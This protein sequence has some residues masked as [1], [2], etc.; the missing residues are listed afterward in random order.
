M[1][2]QS[3]LAAP[4]LLNEAE[5]LSVVEAV[6]KQ[7][8]A[9]GVFVKLTASESALSRFS[10]NQIS[11]NICRDRFKV[12][13]TSYFGKQSASVATTE[14][15]PDAIQA[16]IRRSE[17]LARFAPEDPEWVPLLPPQTYSDR[18]PGFDPETAQ[19]T[20]L[21]RGEKIQ[22]I[23]QKSRKAGVDGSGT[24]STTASLLAIGNSLG[25]RACEKVTEADFSYTAR[26]D[27][28]S[29]W[30]RNSGIAIKD[31]PLTQTTEKVIET[32]RRSRNPREVKPGIYPVIF[33]AAAFASLLP[34]VIWN[35]DARSA[36][37]KRS[38]MSTENSNLLGQQIFSPL[39]QV[40]RDPAHPL[41]QSS[42]FFNDGIPN[43]Y[44]EIIKDGIPQ[45]LSYS[46]YWAQ[47]KNQQPT[48]YFSPIL[49]NGSNAS[50]NDLIAQTERG[51]LVNRAWYVR[52]VNPKTLEVTGMTR[53]GTFLIED[54]QIAYPIKNLRFNQI[55]PEM[56]RDIDALSK[57]QRISSGII[58]GVR[59]KAFN[60]SSVP[61]SV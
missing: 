10:E 24:L 1:N 5:A 56:L 36:D 23:C 47:T 14:L 30:S 32:A 44:L 15:D 54:G 28:G 42:T 3:I 19:I 35:L 55:L 20:P 9:E 16:A 18:T 26:Q 31:L 46:R 8:Q 17:E 58:P 33:D 22:Q 38:F 53:D 52:Y 61:D 60:F 13:I 48:G 50:I 25:L 57:V 59:V 37:E 12:K 39:V 51:I 41:L 34:W 2:N 43:N 40:K 21:Q 7:S 27:N 4:N 11:Q 6:I 45:T 49:M 29:S